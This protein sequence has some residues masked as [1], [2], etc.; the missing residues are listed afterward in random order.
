MELT[1]LHYFYNITT[2]H[3]FSQNTKLSHISP[4][5]INKTIKKLKNELNTQLLIR[6]T[7][8]INLTNQKKILLNH[9]HTMF[10]QIDTIQQNLDNT[11]KNIHNKIHIKTNEIFSTFLLPTTLTKIVQEHPKFIPQTYKM[12]PNQIE[13]NLNKNTLDLNFTL[14]KTQQNNIITKLINTSPN[15]L[16]C[17]KTHP[18]Y[19]KNITTP[20]DL[21]T[22]PSIIPKFFNQ[23]YLPT[24]NQFPIHHYKHQI[25]TTMELIQ[26]RIQITI[27]KTYL[28]YYPKINIHYQLHHNK[29]KILKNIK[30]NHPFELQTTYRTKTKPHT[31]IQII[32]D[33]LQQTII[34]NHLISYT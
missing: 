13:H 22:Y 14:N 33:H 19:N 16:V 15:I 7:Q 12:I 30:P 26:I 8:Q 24:L 27:N 20:K 21:L 11:N 25:N 23:N 18:L 29:L 31:T 9:C 3:S 2:T 32:I 6:T 10:K 28:N 17:K 34:E 1:K 5:T 4:P